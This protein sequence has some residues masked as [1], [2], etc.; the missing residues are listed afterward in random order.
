MNQSMKPE[1]EYS[2]KETRDHYVEMPTNGVEMKAT[3]SPSSSPSRSPNR[4]QRESFSLH[5]SGDSAHNRSE[6][7]D[8]YSLEAMDSPPEATFGIKGPYRSQPRPPCKT[9]AEIKSPMNGLAVT[10]T[11]AKAG[12]S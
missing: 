1:I 11:K 8:I 3:F 2:P 9:V 7:E 12:R 5:F 10:D 6:S 4:A